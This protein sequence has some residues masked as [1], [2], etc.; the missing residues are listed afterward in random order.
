MRGL[1]EGQAVGRLPRP[2]GRGAEAMTPT[3]ALA[4]V[5]AMPCGGGEPSSLRGCGWGGTRIVSSVCLGREEINYPLI[6]SDEGSQSHTKIDFKRGSTHTHVSRAA[7]A[8]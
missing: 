6:Q 8:A 7:E 1:E 5:L 4:C 3:K 2:Q